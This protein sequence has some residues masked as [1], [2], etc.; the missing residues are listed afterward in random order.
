MFLIDTKNRKMWRPIIVYVEKEK[1]KNHQQAAF[2]FLF[3][4]T[5][6]YTYFSRVVV[7]Q[8][9]F[10]GMNLPAPI[11]I[12]NI[13]FSQINRHHLFAD[14]EIKLCLLI[15]LYTAFLCYVRNVYWYFL[16]LAIQSDMRL[17]RIW[18]RHTLRLRHCAEMYIVK[19]K[20]T[21]VRMCMRVYLRCK[22]FWE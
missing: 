16:L 10:H 12:E 20:E 3:L 9:Y 1:K 15:R 18:C 7:R 11:L 19:W 13:K 14:M 8:R 5:F 17:I 2:Y 4:S 21:G 22:L 6:E